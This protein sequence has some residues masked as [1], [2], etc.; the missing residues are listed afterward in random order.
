VKNDIK[1]MFAS[2]LLPGVAYRE[3]L[4]QLRSECK[5]ELEYHQRLADRSIAPRRQDFNDIYSEFKRERFGTGNMSDMFSAL[6]ERIEC[7]QQKDQ[8]YTIKYQKFD[9]EIDQPFIVAIVTRLM[10]RVHKLVSVLVGTNS[11]V[12]KRKRGKIHVQPEAVKRRKNK[13]G[14]RRQQNKGQLV[15]NNPFEKQAGR[16]KRAHNFAQNVRQN[17]PVAKKAGRHMATKTRLYEHK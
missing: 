10:K 4:R 13:T 11:I 5:D 3:F 12:K 2:G 6:E 1:Q 7:L 17:E 15:R 8:D 16:A 14:S 9:E